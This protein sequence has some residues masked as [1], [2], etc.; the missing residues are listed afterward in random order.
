[1][2]NPTWFYA[3]AV[4]AAAVAMAR[5]AGVELPKRVAIFFYL[6]VL[7]FLYLPLTQDYVN[8]PVDFL[9][10]LSPWAYTTADRT[11]VNPQINDITLQIVP[12]AHQVRESWK[13]LTPPLWNAASA[14]GYPLLAIAYVP[15][16]RSPDLNE[17][18]T[19]GSPAHDGIS[20][21]TSKMSHDPLGRDSCSMTIRN[22]GFHFGNS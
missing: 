2:F 12:W 20:R 21:L 11:A 17:K 19:S 1:M 22:L 14:T 3:G 7:V 4:Y 18:L 8:L 16:D 5:R 9:K 10:T 13:T 6:L 15:F